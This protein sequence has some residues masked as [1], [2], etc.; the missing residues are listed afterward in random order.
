MKTKISVAIISLLFMIACSSGSGE[1]STEAEKPVSNKMILKAYNDKYV[2]M[3]GDS[4]L[5]ANET[6]AAK[7][8]V[9]EKIDQGNGKW[10]LK[11]SA[12]K[13]VSDDAGKL[14]A[15]R[16]AVGAW[17]EFEIIPASD[18]EAKINL[19]SHTGKLVCVDGGMNDVLFA[20]RDQAGAWETLT[21]EP[22]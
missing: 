20:S 16:A 22:K 9:F 3:S 8:E 2:V 6:D 1:Q 5:V 14:F 4:A 13:F 19:K 17:E 21:V 11:T 18:T 7:A 12:G 10:A 15:N